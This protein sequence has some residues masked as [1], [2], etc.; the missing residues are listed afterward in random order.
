[1]ARFWR[2]L[3]RAYHGNKSI[4]SFINFFSLIPPDFFFQGYEIRGLENIP[5]SG[6]AIIINYHTA[7]PL[8]AA[9]ILS[10]I[11]LE[12]KRKVVT[13]VERANANFPGNKI[14]A[15]AFEQLSGTVDSLVELLGRGELIL[16]YPGGIRE[17]G[18]SDENYEIVWPERAGFGKVAF[19]AHS[20]PVK[21]T[22][23][24]ACS[25]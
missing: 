13:V 14:L 15:E 18:L 6:P 8:D 12:K 1:M 23:A 16:I 21:S 10:S 11:L 22:S 24:N 20:K 19:A 17:A 2:F 4:K 25:L 3:G 9:F 7:M 5:D